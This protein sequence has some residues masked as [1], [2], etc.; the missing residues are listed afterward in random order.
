ML[1]ATTDIDGMDMQ[2]RDIIDQKRLGRKLRSVRY[3]AGLERAEDLVDL[4]LLETGFS[5]SWQSV[6]SYESGRRT[7]PHAYL[8]AMQVAL[9]LPH[10]VWDAAYPEDIQEKLKHLG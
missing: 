4:L 6:Y 3:D 1:S 9:S 5:V 10:N 2:K 8:I 7:P